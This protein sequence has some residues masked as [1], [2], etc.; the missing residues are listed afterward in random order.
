MR[1]IE[2]IEVLQAEL[3]KEVWDILPY[4]GGK[5]Y[6]LSLESLYRMISEKLAR[7]GYYFATHY[8]I[9]DCLRHFM[10]HGTVEKIDFE[11]EYRFLKKRRK[12][13]WGKVD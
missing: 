5:S 8:N 13:S 4:S 3:R 12:K 11:F 6:G 9:I 1:T 2:S 10:N 7:P